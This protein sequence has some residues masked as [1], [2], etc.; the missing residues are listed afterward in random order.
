MSDEVY[1]QLSCGTFL[2]LLDMMNNSIEKKKKVRLICYLGK[3][4]VSNYS[5]VGLLIRAPNK[6]LLSFAA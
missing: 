2:E 3:V 4:N 1:I 5:Y 6:T